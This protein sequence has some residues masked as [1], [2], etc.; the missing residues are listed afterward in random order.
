[1]SF[2][3][4]VSGAVIAVRADVEGNFHEEIEFVGVGERIFSCRHLPIGKPRG[5][6]VICSPICAD[7]MANYHRE[8]H[9]ARM[10]AA[11]GFAVQR[12]H[13]RGTGNSDGDPEEITFDRLCEDAG[14]LI[15]ELSRVTGVASVALLGTRWGALVA[16]ATARGFPDSPLVL[17]EPTTSSGQYFREAFRSRLMRDAKSGSV[18]EKRPIDFVNDLNQR[19]IV[20]LLGYSVHR[21]LF[22]SAQDRT[23]E[24]LVVGMSRP[25]LIV[26]MSRAKSVTQVYEALAERMRESGSDVSVATA[27]IAESWWFHDDD[28]IPHGP[29]LQQ[30]VDWVNNRSIIAS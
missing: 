26:Q 16:A 22:D 3:S 2:L 6:M 28:T 20:D 30:T 21:A 13:Y 25:V 14:I 9:L 15:E 7:F 5:G 19:G 17:W 29:L 27:G 23:L 1:V 4:E 8:V 10:L 12:F 18:G 11:D 24:P